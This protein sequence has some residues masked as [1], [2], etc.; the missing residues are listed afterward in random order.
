MDYAKGFIGAVTAAPKQKAKAAAQK[1]MRIPDKPRA[2]ERHRRST[3]RP[4]DISPAGAA[5]YGFLK[6][7]F[8]PHYTGQPL[9]GSNNEK[10]G[11]YRSFGLLCSHYG[12]SP[13]DTTGFAYPYGREAALHEAARLLTEKHPQHIEMEL[14]E[15]SGTFSLQV[16]ERFY[17]GNTLFYIPV[18]P[19]QYMMQR[20]EHRKAARLLLCV[21]SYLYHTAGVPYYT[22][23]SYLYWHYEMVTEWLINDPDDWEQETYYNYMSQS[24][25]ALH[26]GEKMLRRLKNTVHRERFGEWLAAF[27]PDETFGRDCHH[28]AQKFYDLW[29]DYPEI[30]LYHHADDSCLPDPEM[31]DYDDGDCITME[32]YVGFVASTD[33]WLY[34]NVEQSVNSYFNESLSKQEPVLKRCF[35]GREQQ[36]DSLEFE[37]RLFPLINELCYLLNNYDYDTERTTI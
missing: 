23:D 6:T 28:I 17:T 25:T 24:R 15:D 32:K 29:R 2:Q 13:C 4:H 22:E 27:V 14:Q 5:A 16:S 1:R 7:R 26:H 34:E 19:V 20:K 10:D 36:A 31:E 21:F 30:S 11:F 35:D 37:C 18:L 3:C 9:R 33:G 8:L 12:I